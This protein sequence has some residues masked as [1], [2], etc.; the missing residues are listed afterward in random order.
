MGTAKTIFSIFMSDPWS[1]VLLAFIMV[2]A[3]IVFIGLFIKP[4]VKKLITNGAV[5]GSLMAFTS[6]AMSFASVAVTFW[7]HEWNF[8]YY[9]WVAGAFSVWTVFVYWLYENTHL[10]EGIH[11]VG[12][13]ILKKFTGLEVKSLTELKSFLKKIEPEVT[14][15]A[16]PVFTETVSTAS[17]YVKS[18]VDKELKNL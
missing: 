14:E 9:L 13:F 18:K 7:V 17:T 5:R 11:W 6:I 15:A 1:F 3:L 12:S 4:F 8:A 10:R 16:K 2:S